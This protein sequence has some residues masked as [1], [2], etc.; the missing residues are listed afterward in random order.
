MA[1]N[2]KSNRKIR[3]KYFSGGYS[4]DP[5]YIDFWTS[6]DEDYK[7]KSKKKRKKK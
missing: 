2:T 5:D 6:Q 1:K 3:M 4:Y 7:A